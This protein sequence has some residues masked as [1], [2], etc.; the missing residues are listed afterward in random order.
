MTIIEVRKF[1]NIDFIIVS[2]KIHIS[3]KK[4]WE[5][6]LREAKAEDMGEGL[7][8]RSHG[9]LLSYISLPWAHTFRFS[10][11]LRHKA[12]LEENKVY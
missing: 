7:L 8:G 12:E 5:N 2:R 11:S 9:G 6:T 10:N 3:S 4:Q 1:A